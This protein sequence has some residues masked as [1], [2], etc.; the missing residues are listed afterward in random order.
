MASTLPLQKFDPAAHPGNVHDAFSDFVEAYA[1]EYAAIA[2]PVPAG[3]Q[4]IPAWTEQ[5]KRKIFLGRF[6]SRNLQRDFEDETEEAE[7]T[8]ITFTAAIAKLKAR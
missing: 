3:T 4:D 7:R 5:D 6:A 8:T 1:Y 2:K